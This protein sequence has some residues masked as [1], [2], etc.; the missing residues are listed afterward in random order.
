MGGLIARYAVTHDARGGGRRAEHVSTIVTFATPQTGS[1]LAKLAD[2]VIDSS[3]ELVVLRMILAECGRRTARK[4]DTGTA[5]DILPDFMQA[6]RTPSGDALQ[7]GSQELKDLDEIPTD[8]TYVDALAGETTLKVPATVGWF[9]TPW[10]RDVNIGDIVVMQDSA[11]HHSS[12][13]TVVHCAYQLNAVRAQTDQIGLTL[14][15]VSAQDVAQP[16]WKVLGPCFHSNLMRTQR[17]TNEATGII[18]DDISK[19]RSA[20]KPQAP[21]TTTVI[22]DDTLPTCSEYG[23]MESGQKDVVLRRMQDDHHD[24]F[25]RIVVKGSV[26]AYCAL[27]PGRHIDGIYAPGSKSNPA[28]GGSGPLPSCSE[29]RDLDDAASDAAL[30]RLARQRGDSS[31]DIHGLRLVV[32]LYCKFKPDHRIDDAPGG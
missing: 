7:V 8:V 13:H 27:N 16:I 29:W 12:A 2:G 15:Q 19:R 14:G 3:P 30:L 22:A 20:T 5:C 11:I 17:L 10:T 9:G 4:F 21:L 32:G 23:A 18:N 24:T 31:P 26:A 6:F 1:Q 25:P 28:D